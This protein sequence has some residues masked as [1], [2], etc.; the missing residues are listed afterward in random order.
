M[1]SADPYYSGGLPPGPPP[2]NADPYQNYDPYQKYYSNRP[3]ESEYS[4]QRFVI[5]SCSHYISPI[6]F[7]LF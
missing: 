6:V 7:F 4:G 1:P 5:S 2:P 3:R